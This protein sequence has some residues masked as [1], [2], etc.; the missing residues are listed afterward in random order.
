M[1]IIREQRHMEGVARM[2]PVSPP[3]AVWLPCGCWGCV[4][5]AEW[6]PAINTTVSYYIQI[7][8]CVCKCLERLQ[9]NTVP[10]CCVSPLPDACCAYNITTTNAINKTDLATV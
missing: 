1:C 10:C 5:D 6:S 3:P 7:F 9:Q 2:G 4:D 8:L